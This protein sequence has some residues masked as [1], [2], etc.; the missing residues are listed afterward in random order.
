MSADLSV[1]QG[2]NTISDWQVMQQQAAILAKSN[3]VPKQF[4]GKADDI[5]V[6]SLMAKELGLGP[7]AALTYIDVIDGTPTVNAEG[8]LA[9]IRQRGHSV[10]GTATATKA[11][12]TGKRADNGDELTV[13]WDIHMAQRAGLANKQVWKQYPE[14]M[15]WSR[16]VSQLSRMIFSDVLMG[17]S[18]TR[19]EV[20]A[21]DGS[22]EP[23]TPAQ[24]VPAVAQ[25][26]PG[27]DSDTGEIRQLT[28]KRPSP[29]AK[30][31]AVDAEIVDIAP[32][33][34]DAPH[35]NDYE[36]VAEVVDDAEIAFA[37]AYKGSFKFMADMA[38]K[39]KDR[40]WTPTDGQRSAI[41]KCMNRDES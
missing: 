34:E 25:L 37:R 38:D 5:I 11:I 24:D 14:A 35:D 30:D 33:H 19:E 16:A 12:V 21:F 15:L 20:E 6:A 29:Q 8:K 3:L 10:K 13:E 1:I 4:R 40:K 39:A 27:V 41:R 23:S 26:N 17:M 28:V 7:I 32:P 36:P 31:E 9:L 2:T 22:P 18:Y